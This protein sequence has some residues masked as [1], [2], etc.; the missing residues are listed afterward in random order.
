MRAKPA[1]ALSLLLAFLSL[2]VVSSG[3]EADPL[4]A[5]FREPP[6]RLRPFVRW[7]WNGSRVT[8]AEILRELDVLEAAGI[9]GVEINTIAMRDDVP[10]ESL[11]RFPE[12]PWLGPAWCAAVKAAAEGARERGMTA[13]LIVG[14]GW[15]F[16]GR[17]LLP[18]E[19][20]KRVRL[21][22]KEL[23]G[24]TVLEASLADLA[25]SGRKEREEVAAV[26]RLA[27]LRLVPAAGTEFDPGRELAPGALR[28]GRLR[29]SVPAGTHVL[30]VGILET[31][32]THVKLGAP[33]A[34]GPVVDHWS[35]PAVR[36]Y[37]DHM[38][39]GL[40]PALG[41]RL[42]EKL[43]GPLRASFVDSLELDHAN[44]TDDL[45]AEFERR[46]GYDLAPYLP[47]V[48]DVD[49][50]ADESPRADAVRR[51]RYDF[52][53]TVVE[54]FQE[55]FLET[56]VAWAHENGLLA[57]MQAYGRE[58]HLLE[59]SLLVD[60]P[61][62]ESWLWS[63]HDRIVVSPT[64]ADKYVSSA[65]HL[66][67]RGPV[68]FEA[69]TN[70]VPV[71]RE[72]PE[73]FKLG[74]DASA[75][76]GVHQPVLHGFNYSPPEA[77]FPGWVRFGS[78][79]NE[80]NPWW[81]HV[82]RFTDYAARLASVLSQTD[83]QASVALLGPRADEWARDGFL[84]QPFPEVQRPWY[85]YHLWQAL[86]QAGYGTDFVSEGVLRG[87]RLE[88]GR[89]RYGPRAYDTLLMMDVVSLEPETA[90]AIARF[91]EAGGRVVV[92]G[93]KPERAPGLKDAAAADRRV[94]E[95]IA[96]L[97]A[98]ARAAVVQAPSRGL[99]RAGDY[100]RDALPD[101]ARR[102]LLSWVLSTTARLGLEPDVRVDAPH[103]DIGLVHHRAGERD[104]FFFANTSRTEA[105]DL[106]ARFPTGDRRP[107]RWDLETGTRAAVPV[108]GRPDTLA[109]HLEPVESL[110]L[111]YE[112]APATGAVPTPR[113]DRPRPGR[114]GLPVVAP[115][116]VDLRPAHGTPFHRRF[117]QLF[118]L[119][120]AAGDPE[121]AG[122]GG[123]ALY[124]AEFDWADESRAI[125]DLG[126]VHG[127]SS[128]R[129]NGKDLGTRWWGRHVYDAAGALAKGRNTLEVEV[130]TTLGNRMRS[131]KD[132]PVARSWA[133][134][135]PPIPM[136]L[137]GPVQL[138]KASD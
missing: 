138:A 53:R 76:A 130:T 131:L 133:S 127:V 66:A 58:T 75:L 79:F 122:F 113:G 136:G 56:Y 78:W 12:R 1:V 100:T 108:S 71:F 120:L 87:A 36:R 98:T 10:K 112:P 129:L 102:E 101:G 135:F 86:Q 137:E 43:G 121:V 8:E 134:W 93:R 6:P 5:S 91:G 110:L 52:H 17:F 105:V 65:A 94:K 62:G 119:S 96:R 124:H 38:S 57:R 63:G 83:F 116:E 126:T 84:Y 128:V 104:V 16:G 50:P 33:G 49:E 27:F 64:V 73:D 46:R 40:A 26:P 118:D 80:Q 89:L 69:M 61:E 72:M 54:L 23:T 92:V 88:D 111:V 29:V 22:K 48:L 19:Q 15:P 14:S 47:F 32:F 9:G 31:G 85:H 90:E 45:P 25:A 68:S 42:G 70:A 20:T 82:R 59:G 114:E 4:Y 44:W 28:G 24:P 7:W 67:G 97:L 41:G 125:L 117:P 99:L 103:P 60:L 115:W 55:R 74:M 77:G 21:V 30:R 11:A 123:V 18:A 81:P 35:A 107:W 3:D 109:L 106:E 51:A 2:A 39:S 34:D 132:N 37:L 95:A 13:D